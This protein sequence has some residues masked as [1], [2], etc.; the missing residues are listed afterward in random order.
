MPR[1]QLI[2]EE[3][4][5]TRNTYT[6]VKCEVTVKLDGK[7]MP[8]LAVLGDALDAGYDAIKAKIADSYKV[9]PAR[10]IEGATV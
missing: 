9:V 6:T 5:P 2:H 8:N 1:S 3:D 10:P 4:I 7:E